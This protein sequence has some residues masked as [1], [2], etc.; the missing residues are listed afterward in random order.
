MVKTKLLFAVLAITWPLV[1]SGADKPPVPPG[2]R[3]RLEFDKAEYVL[4]ESILANWRRLRDYREL[5]PLVKN[6][7]AF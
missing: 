3:F 1:A 4:G 6:D 2:A 5:F 7:G